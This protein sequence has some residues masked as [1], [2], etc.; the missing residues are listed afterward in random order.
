VIKLVKLHVRWSIVFAAD[1]SACRTQAVLSSR[2]RRP[3]Q[4]RISPMIRITEKVK[5][6]VDVRSHAGL[7][8][9]A[10]D[11]LRTLSGYHFTDVTADLM[12]K[13]LTRANRV[14]PGLG[15]SLALAGF[16][17][18]GKSHFLAAFGAILAHPEFRSRLSDPLVQSTVQSLSRRALPVVFVRRGLRRTLM[19]E[20][21]H[22]I[23]PVI[24]CE[25]D[26]LSDSLTEI[27]MRASEST[28]DT[29]L[30][31]LIDTAFERGSR[32]S[33]DDGAVLADIAV[34]ARTLGIFVGIALDDD[35]SGADGANAAISTTFAID[36]LD[37]EHLYKIVD[38]H[39]FP[40][41]SRMQ[42]VLHEIYENYRSSVRSFRWSEERFSSLYPLHPSIMEIAPFIRLYMQDFA[43]LTF[44]SEAGSRILGR[45]ANSLIAPDEVFDSVEKSLRGVEALKEIFVQF[46]R[47][48]A[49]VVAKT[50]VVKRL[51]AK[52]IL[53]G[54]FLFSL[55]DEGATAAEIGAS[56]LIFDE[57]DPE[58]ALR[59]VESVLAAFAVAG[60]DKIRVQAE[61]RAGTR[62]S[63]KLDGK[64]DLKRVL[65]TTADAVPVSVVNDIFKRII[66]ERYTDSS[67][68]SVS[69][70]VVS[71]SSD[72]VLTWRGGS[73]KGR[74]SWLDG[75]GRV[76]DNSRA[77]VDWLAVISLPDSGVREVP[78]TADTPIVTWRPAQFSDDEIDTV[79]R[80][81]V[82]NSDSA[83]RQQ[84]QEHIA[85]AVQA[86]AVAVERIFQRAFIN[87]GVLTIEGFEYN[88]TEEARTAASLSQI[89]TVML[90]SH[91]EGR[92][93][94][95]PYFSKT[96]RLKD[97][98]TLVTD[99]FG[100]ARPK[101]D[102]VQ[103]MAGAF[104]IPLG[105]V[106]ESDSIFSPSDAES[107]R[108]QPLVEQVLEAVDGANG[109]IVTLDAVFHRLGAQPYGLVREAAYLLLSAMVSAR[110]LEFVTSNGD[111]ISH[112]SL[113]LKL[114]WDDIVGIA[115]PAES[116]Y[117]NDRLVMWA[118]L[119]AGQGTFKSLTRSED[120]SAI[121]DALKTWMD[122]WNTRR[123]SE[124]FDKVA[125]DALNTAIWRR[126]AMSTRVFRSAADAIS[127]VIDGSLSIEGCLA[128]IADVFSDSE[129]AFAR[130]R[131]DLEMVEDFVASASL[132]GEITS[133]LALTEPTWDRSIDDVRRELHALIDEN[134]QHPT[135]A[136]NVDLGNLWVR[137]KRL[138]TDH[139][140]DR[141][142]AV[143]LSPYLRE[144]LAEVEKTDI[145]WEFE[146]LSGIAGFDHRFAVEARNIRQQI[147]R[148]DC[149][150]DTRRMFEKMP[151]CGCSFSLEQ[152][153]VFDVMPEKLWKTVT[154]GLSSYRSF[155]DHHQTALRDVLAR[156]IGGESDASTKQAHSDLMAYL[157][158]DKDVRRLS[159]AELALIRRAVPVIEVNTENGDL[160]PAAP[161]RRAGDGSFDSA[162]LAMA[163]AE[164]DASLESLPN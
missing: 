8:N 54:L 78:S 50:P 48:N 41:Q 142:D 120:R 76:D 17:G 68:S 2:Y 44:A 10:D 85:A 126:A 116:V 96:I 151:A 24:G 30:V 23:A 83:F 106:V 22:A 39:I 13:W 137:F 28:G 72:C 32:V 108:G 27:L 56:M 110:L 139:F 58:G 82:L 160:Q 162:E 26:S 133:W 105:V 15:T 5:D 46:D 144:R 55:N 104:G 114:V 91:F 9:F 29:P 138:Y 25:P 94:L 80:F 89:F 163:V 149:K 60:G 134:Y 147:K 155:M 107:L 14:G 123:V 109:G 52:L 35:I 67:F 161:T 159:D 74:I 42:P 73:R 146:N 62:Y 1:R 156:Q 75:S 20:L 112:R 129:I 130:H 125:D 121:L 64:E 53:K 51:Q 66:D 95:H 87:D 61:G 16:R 154:Q 21:K 145:W 81:F 36:Y 141:H 71:N 77:P 88:F 98:T 100:G 101:M 11:A 135:A 148:L 99:L 65:S 118:S 43:L 158:G 150:L 119:L 19:D 7:N 97:V 18:V 38:S 111:R 59:D 34:A 31:L 45:P 63:F 102:D 140:V 47:L 69:E 92:F 3:P 157:S 37:Q 49:E 86:H 113:D 12:A 164:L 90:E 79:R 152:S 124:R 57:R 93:P 153:G 115:V 143:A 40:K 103:E 122:T 4:A 127:A 117:S 70:G 131:T 132:R 136:S 128:Q 33:R 6:I 84:F